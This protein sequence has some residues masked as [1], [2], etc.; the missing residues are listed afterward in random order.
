M[1]ETVYEERKTPGGF[2]VK[3]RLSKMTYV[4]FTDHGPEVPKGAKNNSIVAIVPKVGFFGEDFDISHFHLG[5]LSFVNVK[6]GKMV[7]PYQHGFSNEIKT[8]YLGTGSQ[9]D[10]LPVV[11]YHYRNKEEL[12]RAWESGEQVQFLV[13]DEE[14]PRSDMVT[15]K[16]RYPSL[17]ILVIKKRINTSAESQQVSQKGGAEEKDKGIVDYDKVRATDVAKNQNLNMYSENPVF[18]ARIHLRSMELDKVRQ[19][20]LDFHLSSQ[21]V[22]FIRTFLDVMIRNE[23]QKPELETFKDKLIAMNEAFRL[24]VLILEFKVVEF[25]SELDKK[26]SPEISNMIYALLAKEQETAS[27]IEKE[28][29]LWEWKLRTRAMMYGG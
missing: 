28:I 12:M 2:L 13:V 20:I 26:F 4:V 3:V 22:T 15:F 8:I 29:V 7:I 19:L 18:L 25:E 14:I 27:E 6:A 9:S 24:A 21:D 11:I 16:I 17:N 10:A 1:E 23:N 5:E